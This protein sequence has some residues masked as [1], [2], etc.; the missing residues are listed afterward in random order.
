MAFTQK[1]YNRTVIAFSIV[2]LVWAG[3]KVVGFQAEKD[4]IVSN[5]SFSVGRLVDYS[6]VGDIETHYIKYEYIVDSVKYIGEVANPKK[7]IKKCA[8]YL[9]Y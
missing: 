1:T 5:H 3:Y 2:A 6:I 4:E 7:K 8:E 9:G